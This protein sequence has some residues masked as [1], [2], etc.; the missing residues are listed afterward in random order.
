MPDLV[1]HIGAHKTGSTAIQQ[2]LYTNRAILAQK[3]VLYPQTSHDSIRHKQLRQALSRA[4][5]DPSHTS[6]LQKFIS[7]LTREIDESGCDTVIISDEDFYP[8]R[9]SFANLLISLV[10]PIF[11]RIRVILYIRPQLE[12]W[13]SFYAQE[14]KSLRVLPQ[15]RLWGG[16]RDSFPGGNWIRNGMYFSSI[17]DSYSMLVGFDNVIARL[18]DRSSFPSG[19]VVLDFLGLLDL[20]QAMLPSPDIIDTNPSWGW[21]SIE[22][23]KYLAHCY[24]DRLKQ[25][26]SFRPSI[27]KALLVAVFRAN[28]SNK[29]EWFGKPPNLL[30]EQEQQRLFFHYKHDTLMLKDRYLP[31]L[32]V[33]QWS[34]V[35]PWTS[36]SLHDIPPDEFNFALSSFSDSLPQSL[37]QEIF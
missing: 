6:D 36:L 31:D 32:N 18:Y 25:E 13:S 20:D 30:D 11:C 19:N 14:C 21:K 23:S 15:H 29:L 33:F 34:K 35:L 4:Q 1:I 24:S 2:Y 37:R 9:H 16:G 27:H 3:G 12:V 10:K 22:F 26:P 7:E 17:L 28:H 5:E 8:Q